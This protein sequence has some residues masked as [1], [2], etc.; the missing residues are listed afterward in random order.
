MLELGRGE[1]EGWMGGCL[2]GGIGGG[3]VSEGGGIPHGYEGG[4]LGWMNLGGEESRQCT[5][6]SL[7]LISQYHIRRKQS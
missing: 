3:M 2:R 1:F 6:L 4:Y 5:I 7:C